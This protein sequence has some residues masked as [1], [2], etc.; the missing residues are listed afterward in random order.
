MV[1]GTIRYGRRASESSL[2]FTDTGEPG[3]LEAMENHLQEI[4][5]TSCFV[6]AILHTF[7]VKQFQHVA[8]KFPAG[9][10]SENVFHLLGEVEVV[11]GLWAAVYLMALMGT[12]GSKTAID[13]LQSRNFTEPT[14]VFVIMVVC[15]TKPILDLASTLIERISRVIPLSRPLAFYVAALILGPLLGS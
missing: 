4:M 5:A 3:A 15:S 8:L 9:S 6:A 2:P 1:S 7:L 10:V 13:Y 11:F 14:F 12:S